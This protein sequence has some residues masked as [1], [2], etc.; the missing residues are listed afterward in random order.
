MRQASAAKVVILGGGFAGLAA[1]LELSSD[2]DVT[3][4]DASPSFEFQ[5][6]IHELV[7]RVKRPDHLRLPRDRIVRLAGHRFLRQRVVEIDATGQRVHLA[8]GRRLPYDVLLVTVGGV[9]AT[10]GVPG[11]E[12]HAIPFK[13]VR[14]CD[15]IG[16]RLAQLSR[17]GRR[18]DVVI[19]GG[20]LEGVE[21]LGEI[22]R[23]YR[24]QSCFRVRVVEARER[25]LPEGPAAL[26]GTVRGLCADHEIEFLTGVP[27]REVQPE[28]VVLANGRRLASRVTLWTGGPTAPALLA[29]AGLSQFAGGWASVTK[30]LQSTAHP[31]IFVAG[32]CAELPAPVEKQAY[33]AL[34]MGR[35]AARNISRLLEGRALH[36]FRASGKPT[37]ISFGD[38]SCF[39]VSGER[40][41]AA[42]ALA[43]AKEA[44]FEIGM[45][46]LDRQE[47]WRAATGAARRLSHAA[48]AFLWPSVSSPRAWARQLRFRVG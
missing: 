9:N 45:A 30:T 11:V 24:R 2:L 8:R 48:Q 31:A 1:A 26:D 46:Q 5:P 12:D 19:V 41:V 13:S 36:A 37:L 20:G 39:L 29:R 47:R 4:V 35:C 23:A 38:L 6:N 22:L 34:D 15:R 44:V 27:V 40:F 33:H 25:L 16:R 3:L 7:S 28:A 32:D 43:A 21:A 17:T 18:K 10:H 14:D 42:P